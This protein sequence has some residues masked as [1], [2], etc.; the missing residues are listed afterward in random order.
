MRRTVTA[1]FARTLRAIAI[2]SAMLAGLPALAQHAYPTPEAAADA[3]GDAIARSDTDALR[4]VLGNNYQSLLPPGGVV[5]DDI[6]D[7]L[8]AWSRHHAIEPDGG[9]RARVAVGQSGWTFPAP[10]VR[11]RNGWQFDVRAGQRE[12]RLRRL[13]RNELVTMET[14]LAL[15]DAQQR[16]ADAVG[17]G[18]YAAQLVSQPGKTDGLYWP[19]DSEAN[20][21]P[22][23]PDAL[24][25]VPQTPPGEA[26]YGYY[27]RVLAPGQGTNE[28]FAFIAWP[29]RYGESGVHTFLLGSDRSFYE[30][31]F[32]PSTAARVTGIRTYSTDG[33]KRVAEER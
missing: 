31:D 21:S 28:R 30:R 26:Y 24:A 27:F 29:A 18:R 12:V 4:Q 23:G 14:L 3:L 1:A 5:Q 6:Y 32:G 11:Q 15:A 8:A 22:F 17:K 16:Y 19:A 13:G 2:G 9:E 7:F 10:L 33:W 20:A 25:M